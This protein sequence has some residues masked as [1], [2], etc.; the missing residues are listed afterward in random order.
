MQEMKYVLS[1]IC[2]KISKHKNFNQ[3]YLHMELKQLSKGYSSIFILNA[4]NRRLI[5]IPYAVQQC[6]QH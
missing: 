1:N 4:D 2:V 6:K 3:N 5:D